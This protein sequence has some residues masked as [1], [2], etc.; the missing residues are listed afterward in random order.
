MRPLTW[1]L[2]EPRVVR[3]ASRF[4]RDPSSSSPTTSRLTTRHS[5][6]TRSAGS[7]RRHIAVAMMGEMLEDYRHFRN[8]DW[9]PGQATTSSAHPPIGS[10][11]RS[12]MSSRCR[13][14]AASRP[15][16]PMQAR[17]WTAVT[18]CRLP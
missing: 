14:S 8:P 1:F 6:S 5:L 10:S 7:A 16:S 12:S 18:A 15:A 17:L 9:P 3:P 11:P 13:A 4:R 2:A